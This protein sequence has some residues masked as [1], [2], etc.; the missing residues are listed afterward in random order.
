MVGRFVENEQVGLLHE[1][2]PEISAHDPA[3]AEFFEWT[4]EIF[5]AKGE[6]GQ[7]LF[8]LRL[9]LMAAEFVETLVDIIVRIDIVGMQGF[10]GLKLLLQFGHFWRN[11]SRKFEDGFLTCRGAF[12]WQVTHRD[13]A[14][15]CDCAGVG[16]FGAENQRKERGL[17][18]AV[19]ADKADAVAAIDLK[20]HVLEQSARTI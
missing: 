20:G 2:T 17:A 13:V 12:L 7:N 5:F 19:G 15:E 9:K 18:R 1:Q 14:L 10:P 11:R 16:G 4:I 3:A 6:S 8:G